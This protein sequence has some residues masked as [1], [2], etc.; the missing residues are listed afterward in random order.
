MVDGK[1]QGWW[2]RCLVLILC[3]FKFSKIVQYLQLLQC[4]NQHHVM[5][6]SYSCDFSFICAYDCSA[7]TKSCTCIREQPPNAIIP[8]SASAECRPPNKA[9]L[10]L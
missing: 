8:K 10:I 7:E 3:S 2:T 5:F 6:L 1:M 9:A 4:M